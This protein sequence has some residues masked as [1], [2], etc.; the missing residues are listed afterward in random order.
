MDPPIAITPHGLR[1]WAASFLVADGTNIRTVSNRLG[2]ASTSMTLDVYTHALPAQD[3][4]A[5]NAIGRALT[6]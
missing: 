1:H 5:A 4:D 3:V 2:H 6:T